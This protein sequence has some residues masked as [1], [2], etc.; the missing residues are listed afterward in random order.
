MK[1]YMESPNHVFS[2]NDPHMSESPYGEWVKW[3]D[4]QKAMKIL[5]KAQDIWE[6]VRALREVKG[7]KDAEL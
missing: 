7:V 3:E 2:S 6:Y 5:F 1:R 4:I